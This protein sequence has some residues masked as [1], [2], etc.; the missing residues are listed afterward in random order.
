VVLLA[1]E[2]HSVR[3]FSKQQSK[4]I[5]KTR[6]NGPMKTKTNIKAGMAIWGT[7]N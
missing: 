3:A 7:K 5:K 6:E 2:L 4:K 1:A